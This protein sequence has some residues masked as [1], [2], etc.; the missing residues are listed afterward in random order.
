M[1]GPKSWSG[2]RVRTSVNAAVDACEHIMGK[3]A[4]EKEVEALQK[5]WFLKNRQ[6]IR[7]KFIERHEK[8]ILTEKKAG[9]KKQY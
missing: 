6:E 5:Q 4:Q 7:D 1:S 8:N 9:I 3:I 2:I